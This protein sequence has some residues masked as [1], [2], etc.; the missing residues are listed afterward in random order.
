MDAVNIRFFAQE[1]LQHAH[2]PLHQW[3]FEQARELGI[4]GG[5]VFRAAAGFGRHGLQEDA[6]FELAGTLPESIEFFA[7]AGR[8]AALAAR[9]AAAG[10]KLVYVTHPVRVGVTGVD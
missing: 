8:I 1:G 6:F 4:S 2:Q 3:L 9:V 5:T 7:D 10:L